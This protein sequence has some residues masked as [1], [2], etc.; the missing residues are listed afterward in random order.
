MGISGLLMALSDCKKRK[1]I[2]EYADK[3]VGID[4]SCWL[5][6]G[7]YSC[8][9]K[10]CKGINTTRYVDYCIKN[11]KILQRHHV[12]PLVV[13]D[14]GLL[15]AKAGTEK[16]RQEKRNMA[17]KEAMAAE[18]RNDYRL[19]RQ[20]YVRAVDVTPYMCRKLMD[21]LDEMAVT[22]VVA[23]YEADAQLAFLA[24]TGQVDAVISEDSDL[25]TYG[26]R[27]VLYKWDRDS[28]IGD[29]I[30]EHYA[31]LNAKKLDMRHWTK[32]QF[33][34]M[35][36]FAG[37]DYLPSLKGVA[38][39]KAYHLV[40]KYKTYTRVLRQ[41]RFEAKTI[42]PRDYKEGFEKA[43]LTFRHALVWDPRKEKL[44][45]LTPLKSI[46]DPEKLEFLGPN[47]PRD[48]AREI[49]T[50]KIDP[51]TRVDFIPDQIVI[52][53][54]NFDTTT[55]NNNNNNNQNIRSFMKKDHG[56]SSNNSSGRSNSRNSNDTNNA[57]IM[58]FRKNNSHSLPSFL[59]GNHS[60]KNMNNNEKSKLFRNNS[61]NSNDK[62]RRFRASELSDQPFEHL[63]RSSAVAKPF[64]RPRGSGNGSSSSSDENI[65]PS[66]S[67]DE[68]KHGNKMYKKRLG[69]YRP[70]STKTIGK[71]SKF[72]SSSSND[73]KHIVERPD[74][75]IQNSS[76]DHRFA[77]IID[78]N[79][80]PVYDNNNINRDTP[81]NTSDIV[82]P[83]KPD[84]FSEFASPFVA[85]EFVPLSKTSSSFTPSSTAYDNRQLNM[86]ASSQPRVMSSIEKNKASPALSS[87][88]SN[89]YESSP[90]KKYQ[91]KRSIDKVVPDTPEHG[92]GWTENEHGNQ[93]SQRSDDI[94]GHANNDINLDH[95]ER[96]IVYPDGASSSNNSSNK[97]KYSNE[98]RAMRKTKEQNQT[99]DAFSNFFYQG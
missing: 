51:I 78:S 58:T 5:H 77:P 64:K 37:C 36:I 6:K 63:H 94:Y 52:E 26:C 91:M 61:T 31:M 20:Y 83:K 33:L 82:L 76:N 11:I 68:L 13:F 48:L 19:A 44:V 55:T 29:E 95:V 92:D 47:I 7:V 32:D 96:R 8:S 43:Q 73:N 89:I 56:S 66:S 88:S 98:Y 3:T 93:Y 69:G 4:I 50:G 42:I 71:R 1:H 49:C 46:I 17:L 41:L 9:D 53:N 86:V 99:I 90:F 38:I 72:F 75:I 22:Y 45:H 54:A 40:N 70:S 80:V 30:D 65:S 79:V 12:T 28:G 57:S 24:R 23:P 2:K 35:C 39:T 27:R 10:I 18:K 15:P 85:Q 62:K 60:N 25:L 59:S 34:T 84:V 21:K 16:H 74:Q 14:G 67:Q 81:K 97:K 87:S